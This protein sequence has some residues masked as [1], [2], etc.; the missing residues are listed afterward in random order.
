MFTPIFRPIMVVVCVGVVMMMVMRVVHAFPLGLM[1]T[2]KLSENR[3]VY[4]FDTEDAGG[5]CV[6]ECCF[7]P[8]D[9]SGR[10]YPLTI[11]QAFASEV[12]LEVSLLSV[13]LDLESPLLLSPLLL[14]PSPL[15]DDSLSFFA[16]SL[17]PSLR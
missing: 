4:A 10:T 17:Y 6:T 12:D 3:V 5:R 8:P 2:V 7:E 13:L 11:S 15:D 14:S 1:D 16:L 9:L